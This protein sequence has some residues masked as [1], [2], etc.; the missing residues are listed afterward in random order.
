[1]TIWRM[2]GASIGGSGSE[3]SSKQMVSFMPG[4]EQRRQRVAVAQRVEQGVADG[5][6]GVVERL[7]RLGRVDHPA[8]L[9]QGLEGE[10]LAVPEQGRRRGLVHLEDETGTAAH[11]VC[12][13]VMSKAILT[14]PA[15][16]GGAG[17]GHG[18]F[19]AGQRVGGRDEAAGRLGGHHLEG[20]VEGGHLFGRAAASSFSRA[21]APVG[22]GCRHAPADRGA[23]GPTRCRRRRRRP[24]GPRGATAGPGRPSPCPAC[25]PGRRCPGAGPWPSDWAI[26]SALPTQS[27]TTSAPPDRVAVSP[28]APPKDSEWLCRRTARASWSG[29]RASVAPNSRARRCWWA[30]WAPTS[31]ARGRGA[32][33]GGGQ[34]GQRGGD[35]E[36]ERAG[37]EHG[38]H[39]A[40]AD[41]G[42]EHGVHG[43]GHRL[44]G[45][46]VGV[47][48]PVGDGEE[49]A[50]VRH[51]AGGRPPAAGVG[52]EAG[53][54]AG[55]EVAEGQ[56]AAVADVAGGAGRRRA[57]RC[58]GRRSRAP[59]GAPPGCPAARATPSAPTASSES[60]PTTSWPGTKGNET[61]SSK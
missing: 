47:A 54:Q 20:Q 5:A 13:F 15:A 29:G 35:G 18:F 7:H 45:D 3:M 38:H 34:V 57:G 46:G 40:L 36:P 23:P 41:A 2:S 28:D 17:V 53:L 22:T 51:Q 25:R 37:P 61:I 50:R 39:V 19:E 4:V 56:V 59:A 10:A 11:R 58:R 1:M 42:A 26:D 32:A 30:Y 16:P 12:P 8:A 60:R 27:M 14:A 44:D 48:E 24:G 33:A 6:V 55:P 49:L 9:G 43:A 21:G 52:A 31:S